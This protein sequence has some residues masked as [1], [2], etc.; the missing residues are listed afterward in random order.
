M[1]LP[2]KRK[3]LIPAGIVL[4]AL[5]PY[6]SSFRGDFQFSDYNVIVLNPA[7][8]SWDGWLNTMRHLGIRPLLKFSYTL[9]WVSG[10]GIFGYHFFNVAVHL[11]SSLLVLFLCHRLVQSCRDISDRPA[12]EIPALLAALLFAVHP[13]HTE[14]ITYIS[15]RSSSMMALFYLGSLLAYVKGAEPGRWPLRFLVSPLCFVAA[16]ATKEVAVTLPFALLLWE[17]TVGRKSWK[18]IFVN[19]SVHWVLLIGL[20]AIILSHPRYLELLLFSSELRSARENLLNQVGGFAYLLS[21]LVMVNKLNIDPDLPVIAEASLSTFLG[22][23]VFLG[24][25]GAAL[26]NRKRRPWLTFGVI[27]F[28]LVLLPSNSVVARLD[29]VN[30][31]HL[32]L[33]DFG[34]FLVAGIATAKLQHLVHTNRKALAGAFACTLVLLASFTAARNSDYHTPIGFWESTVRNS[35]SKARPHNNLGCAYERAGEIQ[36]AVREYALAVRLDPRD[37]YA[38]WN[39]NRW[40]P[41]RSVTMGRSDV[42][43]A[44]QHIN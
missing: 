5:L 20:M 7:V 32:Y 25:I 26:W 27:W 42:P 38:R 12:P 39:L 37:E 16:V 2:G 34:V 44:E 24:L 29:I 15:G 23:A 14:A 13:I 1:T 19:Q 40:L 41:E 22:M 31:R 43:Q 28:F 36:K 18:T 4:V 30:E 6:L 17:A 21:R 3:Y 9:N 10:F 8:H 35:P 11:V 33:A